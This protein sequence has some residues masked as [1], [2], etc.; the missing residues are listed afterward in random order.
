[1]HYNFFFFEKLI[2]FTHT[3]SLL[4]TLSR[5]LALCFLDLEHMDAA[6]SVGSS[7]KGMMENVEDDCSVIDRKIASVG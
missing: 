3:L 6:G 5:S 2:I 4:V 1:M 7:T